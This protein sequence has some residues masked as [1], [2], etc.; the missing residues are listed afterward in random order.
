MSEQLK[1]LPKW[2][3]VVMLASWIATT[4]YWFN[5]VARVANVDHRIKA[6]EAQKT[7]A[8]VDRIDKRLTLVESQIVQQQEDRERFY[9]VL[10]KMDDNLGRLS[11][12][13]VELRVEIKN[14]KQ[15]E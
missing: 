14:L 7:G 8:R 15:K 3:L 11:E 6:L 10:D 4:P 2:F 9:K 12:A 1:S 5:E 13:V